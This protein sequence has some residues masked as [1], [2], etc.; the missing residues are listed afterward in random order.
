VFRK[1]EEDAPIDVHVKDMSWF[2]T[3]TL[4]N[5]VLTTCLLNCLREVFCSKL[6]NN[7]FNLFAEML[8]RSKLS[9]KLVEPVFQQ[10]STSNSHF[11]HHYVVVHKHLLKDKHTND[12]PPCVIEASPNHLS[13]MIVLPEVYE[14]IANMSQ[15]SVGIWHVFLRLCDSTMC[16]IVDAYKLFDEKPQ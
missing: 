12:P 16:I 14:L 9:R 8:Q 11:L 5:R 7:A 10:N 13:S 2:S 3:T 6:K 1:L 15:I 4:P